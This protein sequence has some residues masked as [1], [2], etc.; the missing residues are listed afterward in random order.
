MHA[1]RPA[2]LLVIIALTGCAVAPLPERPAVAAGNAAQPQAAAPASGDTQFAAAAAD[3]A[4]ARP[5]QPST[6]PY[7]TTDMTDFFHVMPAAPADGDAR[8]QA[9]R[10]IFRETRALQGSP[11]WQMAADDAE[12]GT[13]AMLRHFSCSL[14]VDAAPEQLPRTVAVLQKAMREAA[15]SVGRAKDHYQRK[16]P[17]LVDEGA[18]CV[19]QETIG[20]SYDY[21]SGHTTAGWAWALVLAQVDP[22]RAQ[23]IL[24]RGRAIGDSRV[25]CGMHNASAVEAARL[26]TGSAMTLISASPLYQAD[27]LAARAELAAL[28]DGG[29]APPDAAQCALETG[30]VEKSWW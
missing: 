4:P 24:K 12:L 23:P 26:L 18:T 3:P 7:N 21:P 8:D 16:R 13:A 17:F 15:R 30:L 27:V 29:A 19:T 25:V 10:R 28:R 9:D 1:K 14:G 2:M 6:P 5:R 11:R 20:E 22:E